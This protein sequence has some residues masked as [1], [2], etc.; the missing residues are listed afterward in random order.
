[1][2]DMEHKEYLSEQ[3]LDQVLQFAQGL[4]NGFG[5]YGFYTP[6]SQNQNLLALNNN[7][8]K[9]TQEKLSKALESVPYDYGSLASYSEFMEIWDAIYAKTL[10]YFGG[11]L[12]FDLSYTCKNIK[13]PSDYNSKEYKDDIKRVHK[14]LDNFDYKTEFD[15]VVKQ[16]L[17]TEICYT[18]FRDSH[19]DLNSP[20]DIDSDEGKIRKNEKFS[21]QMMPQK[22]CMLTGYF[23]CSQLLYDFDIN[24]FLN[25]DVDINLF[26]PVLKK[27]F[28]E[29]YTNENGEY[30]PSAQLNYRNGS[31]AN[32]VQCSPNDGAYAFKFDLSNF[33]QVP[34]LIAL[35]K[36]CLN[37]D[38][39]EDLQK[40]K[41]MISAYLLL[42]GEI[43]TMDT[44]KSGNKSN[45][46]S[47]DP[48]TMGK[49]MQLVKSGLADKVKPLA[50]P[51]EDIKG[52]QFTDSNPSMVEKQYT[53]T[54]AQGASAST[55]IYTTSKM[56]QSELENAIYTDYCF[57]KPL[58]E[59]F[60]QFL[61]FYVNKKTTKYKFEFSFDGLNRPWDRKQRQETLRNFAD[62]GIVLD[63]TQW[64]SAYGMKPQAFQRS[65]ECAHNDTTF[66]SNLTMMLNANTM[67]SSG[68]D[69][70]GAPKKDSS[71]RSDKTE[72][73]SDYVD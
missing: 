20:I 36:S 11:L 63:A 53:T 51:L 38:E 52:W 62:K 29:S 59:Q 67:Q 73:V 49:F 33:R 17:R 10:R 19:E 70:I 26:A 71:E 5:G 8:Q 27:K 1:M 42:A 18:W 6:F 21:L 45:Q 24:Y 22:N 13:N 57:M 32:W 48:K 12:S 2:S 37:N 64:A 46:F 72:E 30:I 47:I 60:N 40:N 28:K 9:P 7:G 50:L 31:F 41:D 56:S 39:I 35:L 66:I 25:G 43:K 14:F 55:L 69:N 16:I 68:E 34:P 15:K 4:Y 61:N 58:Y 23:N 44:D 54:A 3:E 65:L